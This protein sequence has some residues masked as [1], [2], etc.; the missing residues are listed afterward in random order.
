[1][2]YYHGVVAFLPFWL[3]LVSRLFVMFVYESNC[4]TDEA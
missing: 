2:G 3:F 4:R 1:M